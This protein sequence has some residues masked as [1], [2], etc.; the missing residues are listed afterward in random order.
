LLEVPDPRTL[1]PPQIAPPQ[2]K[3]LPEVM[4]YD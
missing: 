4:E 3:L 1:E 2:I